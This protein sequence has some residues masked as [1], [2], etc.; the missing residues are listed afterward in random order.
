MRSAGT[1]GLTLDPDEAFRCSRRF[2]G[3][4]MADISDIM[5]YRHAAMEWVFHDP[6]DL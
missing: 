5:V 1:M 4:H 6:E 2:A 3:K